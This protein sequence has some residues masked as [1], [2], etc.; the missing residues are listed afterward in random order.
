MLI[1]VEMVPVFL[2]VSSKIFC[3]QISVNIR[4]KTIKT[5]ADLIFPQTKQL[6]VFN[7]NDWRDFLFLATVLRCWGRGIHN[8]DIIIRIIMMRT[9]PW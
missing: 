1:L 8:T 2:M 9:G 4:D 6:T 5:S 7:D 3:L